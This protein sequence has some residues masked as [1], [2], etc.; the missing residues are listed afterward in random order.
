[1]QSVLDSR[2]ASVESFGFETGTGAPHALSAQV[3]PPR[4]EGFPQGFPPGFGGAFPFGAPAGCLSRPGDQDNQ[5]NQAANCT[6]NRMKP[7][8]TRCIQDVRC[9]GYMQ[10]CSD[11]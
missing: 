8:I 10:N 3:Q 1:M 6:R 9:P 7:D 4:L 11:V 5:D 2:V